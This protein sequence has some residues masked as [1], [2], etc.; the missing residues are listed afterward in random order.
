MNNP[1]NTHVFAYDHW[2]STLFFFL[3]W[4]VAQKLCIP[5]ISSTFQCTSM[6]N[7]A[8]L[9]SSIPMTDML[10]SLCPSSA[11]FVNPAHVLFFEDEKTFSNVDISHHEGNHWTFRD[12]STQRGGGNRATAELVSDFFLCSSRSFLVLSLLSI[13]IP[14][15]NNTMRPVVI[16]LVLWLLFVM[17]FE[18]EAGSD[19]ICLPV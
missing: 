17:Y 16:W 3:S 9:F 13:A 12:A 7:S 8:V 5:L 19:V 11:S 18:W 1:R 14:L 10:Y 6:K 2:S 4:W 15:V